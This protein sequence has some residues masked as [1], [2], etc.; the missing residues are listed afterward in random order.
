VGSHPPGILKEK[1]RD[2]KNSLSISQVSAPASKT[3]TFQSSAIDLRGLVGQALFRQNVGTVTG[4]TPTLDG[5]IQTSVDGSTGWTDVTGAAYTQVT[6]SNNQQS[7]LVD[8]R[9][10]KRYARYSGTLAGTSPNYTMAVDMVAIPQ[11]V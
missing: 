5:K 11:T 6:A 10:V 7:L 3:A 1:M 2:L 4:T 8:V 9:S